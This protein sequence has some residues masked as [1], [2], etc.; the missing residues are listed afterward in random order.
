MK[1][2]KKVLLEVGIFTAV[3]ALGT[4]T[5]FLTSYHKAEE[6][7][8]TIRNDALEEE[9]PVKA[10]TP[11]DKYLTNLVST[12][13]IAGD[14][15]L[16]ISTK[17]NSEE[18]PDE[19]QLNNIKRGLEDLDFGDI[20]ID[21]KNVKLSIADLENIKLSADLYVQ[22]G[23]I[24]IKASLGYFD[25]TIYLDYAET[26]FKLKTD[27]IFDFMDML[28][29]FGI[30]MPSTT[31]FSLESLDIDGLTA[32]LANLEEHNEDGQHYFLFNFN[33]DIAIKL[34]SDDE[35]H[36]IGVELPEINFKGINISATSSLHSLTEDI[37]DLINPSLKEGAHEYIEFK[38]SFT[39]INKVI[40]LVNA[41]KAKVN[42]DV[43]VNRISGGE[44]SEDE[45]ES[46]VFEDFIDLKGN[47]NFDINELK[48]LADLGVKY[49]DK[50]YNIS[51]GYQNETIFASYKN[52]NLSITNQSVLTLANFIMDKM[53]NKTL[54]EILENLGDV[55]KEIDIDLDTILTYV[56]D[57]PT[58]IKNFDLKSDSLS[59][60]VSP[61]YFNIPVSDF[62]LAINWDDESLKSLS[63][64]GLCYGAYQV[65]VT[66]GV[67]AY[68]TIQINPS[69]YV[70]LDP[71]ISLVSSVEKLI[72]Q[73][74]YGVSFSLTMDDGD[75]TTNDL[76][77]NG[78]MHFTI[79]DKTENDVHIL[80][81]K[82][83]FNYGSGE[84]TIYDGDNYPHNIIMDAQPY[85]EDQTGQVL[86][87]YGGTSNHRT[88][89]M[90]QYST[91]DELFAKVKSITE[92]NDSNI[93]QLIGSLMSSAEASPISQI[94]SAT[95]TSDYLKLLDYDII[96]H[97]D[98]SNT[99]INVSINGD[100]LGFGTNDLSIRIRYEGETIKGL[101]IIGLEFNGKTINF[102]GELLE[103][104]QDVYEDHHLV[105]DSSYIDLSTISQFAEQ[106]INTLDNNYYHIAGPVGLDFTN[107]ALDALASLFVD[108][109][110]NLDAQL[111]N[112]SGHISFVAH[113]SDI[114]S[115][116][117]VSDGYNVGMDREAWLIGDINGEESMFYV[118]RHDSWW[119]LGNKTRDI[120]SKYN[121]EGFKE[122]IMTIFLSDVLGLSS[123]IM[124]SVSNIENNGK[125]IQYENIIDTYAY[126][127]DSEIKDSH[128]NGG[129]KTP[130]YKYT[131]SLNI[132][133][134]AQSDSLEKL[135]LDAYVDKATNQLSYLDLCLTL[136]AG[137]GM[138]VNADLFFQSDTSVSIEGKVLKTNGQTISSYMEEHANDPLN[139]RA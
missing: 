3:F 36:M 116:L 69:E 41:K 137:V 64:T 123:T 16:T 121:M 97:L 75:E 19:D 43:D 5:G 42:L 104:D 24:D 111:I 80:N 70:A 29:T 90:I 45:D 68:K 86:L 105:V 49:S 125:Q 55:S 91:F 40:E 102:S 71:A 84:L 136:T 96:T 95:E 78:L 33:K 92:N 50:T 101:D 77:A 25:S 47:I 52:L 2:W 30:D 58:Y 139:Q 17:G 38:H 133:I 94:L 34:L 73:D 66:L 108:T 79:R 59:L 22:K 31:S 6:K 10:Q 120:Y 46:K 132:G 138:K 9:P 61:S 127:S 110:M 21:I 118:H 11:A 114:P 56:R 35:Y 112:N 74:T 124:S 131:F 109:T 76:R 93:S 103:F 100:F 113:I 53:G 8:P 32:S 18:T 89:A 20:N 48:V 135:T 15:S 57:L 1:T 107:G 83:T 26:Y 122:N 23:D 12:K 62:D 99:E 106:T 85:T 14:V 130:A 51:A 82:R 126:S 129:A 117:I 39:L 128:Y 28:P 119:L 37:P 44:V 60:T 7:A 4:G 67:D 72:N 27:D 115:A 87:S 65:N 88:N 134:L 54:D 98:I 13:A 81:T 63:L